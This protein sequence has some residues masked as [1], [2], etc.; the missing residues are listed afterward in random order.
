MW[1]R[2]SV[3]DDPAE[4]CQPASVGSD[5]PGDRGERSADSDGQLEWPDPRRRRHDAGAQCGGARVQPG[6]DSRAPGRRPTVEQWLRLKLWRSLGLAS[7]DVPEP[8]EQKRGNDDKHDEG[9]VTAFLSSDNP[10]RHLVPPGRRLATPLGLV[11]LARSSRRE[12]DAIR[13]HEGDA[14]LVR[15]DD[16]PPAELLE[17]RNQVRV[18]LP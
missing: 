3:D 7:A 18:P 11:S 17:P 8:A 13:T 4:R 5:R 1:N 10:C 2:A 6:D 15:S 16:A 14:L 12:L 9:H